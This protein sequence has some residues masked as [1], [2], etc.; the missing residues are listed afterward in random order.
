MV[1]MLQRLLAACCLLAAASGCS[2]K[3][4]A[5]NKFASALTSGGSTYEEDDDPDLVGA[6]LPFG[7]KLM[8][9]LLSESPK[10]PDL[11]QAVSSGFTEYSYAF[12]EQPAA[13]S[14]E[15][16]DRR[17]AERARARRL[18]LRAHAYGMR[19]LD[20]RYPGFAVKADQDI[21]AALA[22]TRKRD[23]PLLY[24]TA[25]SLGL[26][27]SASKGDPEMVGRL[28]VVE[29]LIGRVVELDEAWS[30]G[31]VPEFLISLESSRPGLSKAEM[32]AR[33]K[34]HF[35]RAIELSKGARAGGYVSYAENACVAAQDAAAFRSA[36][37]K[38]LA[39]DTEV[40]SENRLANL[41]AQR[42]ARWLL[43]HVDDLFLE[44]APPAQ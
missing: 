7:L 33:M 30:G 38:A 22:R 23:V 26:A 3:R 31:A 25:A 15:S 34:Q 4:V 18:F 27:I 17:D 8:E 40:K 32:L 11:L 42:R 29:A 9:G 5:V 2:I 28:P 36:I 1:A 13:L 44:A 10:N 20:A 35:D 19:G 41:I 21:A 43:A 6:A 24:W 16:L 12:V 39:V 37:A 14:G